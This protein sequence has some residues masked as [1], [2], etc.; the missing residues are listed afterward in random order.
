MSTAVR[1][2]R[3][4]MPLTPLLGRSY[5]QARLVAQLRRPEV[6]LLTL[7]GPG[8]FCRPR[9]ALAAAHDLLSDFVDGVCFVPLAAIS[10]PSF[11]LPAL[12]QALGLR[13][14]DTRASLEELQVALDSQSLLLLLDNFEQVQAAA[15]PLSDLLAACPRLKLLVTSR[16]SL[17]LRGEY[18]LAVLPLAVPDL[19]HLPVCE[20]LSQYCR[21]R[22]LR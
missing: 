15:P 17:R 8:G 21:L 6:R 4:P 7:T 5:E 9:L 18:E 13:E 1:Y 12:A 2:Q 14:M 16:A 22:T 11:V 19:A 10:D 3:L 20:A